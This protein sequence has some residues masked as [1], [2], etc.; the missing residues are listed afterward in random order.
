LLTPTTIYVRAVRAVLQHYNVKRVVH[1]IAHITGGGLRENLARS[2]PEGVHAVI[3]GDAWPVPPVFRWL[4]RL[5]KID[6]AEMERVFNMGIG[7]TLVVSDFYANS[8]RG[9][10]EASGLACWEIGEIRDG[11][12]GASWA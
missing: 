6:H 8:I 9:M 4:Q 3:H 10:I 11:P 2:L 5:G 7:L 1:G 12:R